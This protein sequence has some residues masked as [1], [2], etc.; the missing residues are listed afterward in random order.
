MR[1]FFF[2]FL[3]SFFGY[4]RSFLFR[5]CCILLGNVM[6]YFLYLVRSVSIFWRYMFNIF[7]YNIIPKC[8]VVVALKEIGVPVTGPPDNHQI[9][10]Q[11]F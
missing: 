2:C 1:R 6:L 11:S 10:I 5:G 4:E 8:Q 9:K 7:S 3:S